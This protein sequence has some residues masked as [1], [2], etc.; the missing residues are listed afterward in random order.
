MSILHR[1]LACAA[2]WLSLLASAQAAPPSGP[3]VVILLPGTSLSDWRKAD[4]P[5]LHKVLTQG[6]VAVMNTRTARLPTDHAR[7]TPESAALTLGAGSRAAGGPEVTGFHPELQPATVAFCTVGQIFT[8]RTGSIAAPRA[9]VNP[10]WAR[11]WEENQAK[12]Y[13]LRPGNLGDAIHRNG[14]R[15][16]V[17]G[18]RFAFPVACGS[19]GI[20]SEV[21]SSGT[22]PHPL[23]DCLIWDAGADLAKANPIIA[24]AMTAV[25]QAN[26]SLLVVSPFVSDLHYRAGERLAPAVLW[27]PKVPT[28]LLYSPSTHHA[29]LVTN[30]DFAPTV[31]TLLG[32]ES[33]E[34]WLPTRAFGHV[35]TVRP[36]PDAIAQ[37]ARLESAAYRQ[38]DALRSLPAIAIV[39]GL[40]IL[41]S[42]LF[43]RR[44]G[45]L[46]LSW[47][48]LLVI[49]ALI[50]S[51]TP[52]IALLWVCG[53]GIVL[54][55][56]PGLTVPRA[57]GAAAGLI[58]IVLLGDMLTGNPL[59]RWGLLGYSAVEG[60]RYY[61]IGNE[62]MGP[63][64]GAALVLTASGWSERRL[65]Q[66]A[67]TLGLTG[68]AV[69][70][71]LSFA[72]AK[73]GGLL[74][75]VAS[76]ATYL[77]TIWGRRWTGTT[78]AVILGLMAVTL[79][80]VSLGDLAR[81][82]GG[83]THIGQ[84]V[85]RIKTGGLSEAADIIT[86]KLAVE[87]HLTYH[88]AW[89]VPLWIS[90]AGLVLV[91]RRAMTGRAKA[92]L[93]SG[94]TAI[95]CCLAVND[96][97]VVAGALCGT[98][99]ICGLSALTCKTGRPESVEKLSRSG[100]L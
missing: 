50:V 71:G 88:S 99:V 90:I 60:A 18:G 46:F 49:F 37:T 35:W 93:Y 13:D 15:I 23:P 94:A 3:V 75:A 34:K 86:R 38:A 92:L 100:P 10:D 51:P 4:A 91:N 56:M 61:G 48:P 44:P 16:V 6:A 82:R 69:L 2:L 95:A 30:T 21:L 80:C 43:G 5:A 17:G 8:R 78:F 70:L 77:W 7:E 31:T 55:K 20:V 57:A 96:A 27:G 76:F 29:G 36:A 53:L 22:L 79:A 33:P 66:I 67:V 81:H 45:F 26:G 74:V 68:I 87:G 14:R 40:L 12:G 65:A 39:I 9:W 64:I 73:A 47:L 84:G 41:S 59:M 62:S 83:Q 28:G 97:G 98:I 19:D 63:L 1:W 42:L 72:G 89:A 25:R 85:E 58:V 24:A 32:A 11:V 54:W 52:F